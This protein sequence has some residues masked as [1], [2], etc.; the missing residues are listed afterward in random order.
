[1]CICASS[2]VVTLW[3]IL[4]ICT[5]IVLVLCTCILPLAVDTGTGMSDGQ[6]RACHHMVTKSAFTTYFTLRIS[7]YS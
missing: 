2:I 7:H 5:S 1:M 6:S 4:S 3:C